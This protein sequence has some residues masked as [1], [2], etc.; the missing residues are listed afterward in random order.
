MGIFIFFSKIYCFVQIVMKLHRC[1][2][3]HLRFDTFKMA[4]V[5]MGA[6][7][8]SLPTEKSLNQTQPIRTHCRL[9]VGFEIHNSNIFIPECTSPHPKNHSWRVSEQLDKTKK[10]NIFIHF[11]LYTCI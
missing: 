10:E 2:D 8:C 3:A 6:M 4:T 9:D 7:S 1:L 11:V 5:T